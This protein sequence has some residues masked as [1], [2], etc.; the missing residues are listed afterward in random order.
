MRPDAQDGKCIFRDARDGYEFFWRGRM[1]ELL[2]LG[3]TVWAM[4]A[5]WAMEAV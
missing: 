4:E 1:F 2:W 5:M 3:Q